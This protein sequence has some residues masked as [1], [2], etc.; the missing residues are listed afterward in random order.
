MSDSAQRTL[1]AAD[2]ARAAREIRGI[3]ADLAELLPADYLE[4]ERLAASLTR[5][6]RQV[7]VLQDRAAAPGAPAAPSERAGLLPSRRD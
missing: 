4:L 6:A 3:A 5:L 7:E 2:L 1:A